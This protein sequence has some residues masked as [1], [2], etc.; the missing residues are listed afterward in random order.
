LFNS[1]FCDSDNTSEYV[2]LN[3]STSN[4]YVNNR[5]FLSCLIND[6]N[7]TRSEIF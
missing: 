1:C 3:L 2:L 5:T 4:L 6:S 7:T